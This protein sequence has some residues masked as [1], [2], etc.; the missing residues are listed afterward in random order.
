MPHLQINRETGT[1]NLP[2]GL[3]I[4]SELTHDAFR[5]MPAFDTA[6]S[7]DY[8]TLPWIHYHL[9]GGRI[10]DRELLVSLC[11]YDQLLVDVSM[12]VNLYPPGQDDWSRYSLDVEAATKRFHDRLLEQMLGNPTIGG[13]VVPEDLPEGWASLGR[14]MGWRF[15]WGEVRSGHDFK[16]GGTCITIGFG[17]RKEEA[18]RMHLRR[19]GQRSKLMRQEPHNT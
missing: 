1:I 16:G 17:N 7:K 2:N 8:G 3:S 13:S 12:T 14:P 6:R 15:P 4:I 11:F 5:L 10:D 18:S 19:M 9:S